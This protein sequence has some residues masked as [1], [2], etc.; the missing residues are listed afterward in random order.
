MPLPETLP[1]AIRDMVLT[2][3]APLFQLGADDDLTAA[4]QLA[5][6]MVAAYGPESPDE[7][8]IA[9]EIV[10]FSAHAL[11]ALAQAAGPGLSLNQKL[12]LR[13]SAVSLSRESHKAQRKL[14]QLRKARRAG[15]RP[16]PAEIPAASEPVVAHAGT[17]PPSPRPS[18]QTPP[19]TSKPNA[20]TWTQA[21]RQRQT[22]KRIAERLKKNQAPHLAAMVEPPDA[23]SIF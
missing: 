23:A 5:E 11:E 20:L 13:G 9:A 17:A 10:S 1:A 2:R 18:P 22:A 4:R 19:A 16:L 6:E 12:R 3:L 14:D 7:L 15:A 21:Y 8:H